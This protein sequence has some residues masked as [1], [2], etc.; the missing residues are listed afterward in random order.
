MTQTRIHLPHIIAALFAAVLLALAF[1]LL[2]LSLRADAAEAADGTV[3]TLSDDGSYAIVTGYSYYTPSITLPSEIDGHPVREIAEYAFAGD[4]TLT[5]IVIPDSVVRIGEGAFKNCSALT[6]VSLP[7]SLSALPYECFSNCSVL[8]NVTLPDSLESIDDY[9]FE[10]CSRLGHLYIPAS[11]SSIGYDV[12][13]NCESIYLDV[14][15]NPYAAEYAESF[16]INTDIKGTSGYFWMLLAASSLAILLVALIAAALYRSYLRKH[17]DKDPDIFIYR[18]LWKV[19]SL[20]ARAFRAFLGALMRALT[21][22]LY[23][24][25][26]AYE[27]IRYRKS[28][29]TERTHAHETDESEK[30]GDI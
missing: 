13:L 3:Y 26:R 18:A 27:K 6:A 23:L 7:T 9:C 28:T 30:N 5:K 2:P 15:D 14:T 16:N 20:L 1:A 24:I 29:D 21:S 11:L 17:P 12:F 25:T 8:K 10:N 22:L 4:T 19:Y